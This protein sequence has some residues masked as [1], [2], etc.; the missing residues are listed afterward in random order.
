MLR[1]SLPVLLAATVALS[2]CGY[3]SVHSAA[4]LPNTVHT[5]AV[6]TFATHTQSYHTEI[7][8][9]N[10]VIREF[11]S[12]TPYKVLATDKPDAGDAVLDG[13]INTFTVVPLTYNIQTGQS[14]SYLI[15]VGASVKVLDR[16]H[17]VLYENKNYT[18]RQQYQTTQDLVSFIQ[19]DPAAVQR[20]SRDFAQALVSDIL[21]SF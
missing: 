2:G 8:F 9:T 4:H 5:L 17:R 20:L 18:F 19:E 1:F 10:A 13:E 21:E 16:D 14:S 6:P 12:R 11:T 15:T 3:H 7:A